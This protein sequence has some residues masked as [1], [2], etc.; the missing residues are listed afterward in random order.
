MFGKWLEVG[1]ERRGMENNFVLDFSFE[2]FNKK[3]EFEM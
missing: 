3:V 2:H 1:E